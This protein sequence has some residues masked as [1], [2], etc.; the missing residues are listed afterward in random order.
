M[1]RATVK[2]FSLGNFLVNS[3]LVADEDARQAL[4][5]DAPWGVEEVFSFAKKKSLSVTAVL[6][7]HGHID[8]IA[9]LEGLKAPFFI[10]EDDEKFLSDSTLNASLFLGK[11]FTLSRKP[12]LIQE[13]MLRV[14]PFTL[15]VIHTPGHTPGSVSFALKDWLFCGDTLFFGSVGRTDMPGASGSAL[16]RS[17]KAKIMERPQNTIVF[18]GHGPSTTIGQEKQRNPFLQ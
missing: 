4:I 17:L 8:H 11:P 3:Y 5:I 10:H 7:T 18:P 15:E 9:G 2:C 13:G 12:R 6:L 14:G 1:A 16:Q